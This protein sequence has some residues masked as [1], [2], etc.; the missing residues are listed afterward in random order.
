MKIPEPIRKQVLS[1]LA[2]AYS[3]EYDEY[4]RWEDAAKDLTREQGPDKAEAVKRMADDRSRRLDGFKSA[5]EALGISVEELL[6]AVREIG[7][8]GNT[9]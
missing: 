5:A 6:Q 2:D 8:E 3:R 1:A 9:Q 7:E 4:K